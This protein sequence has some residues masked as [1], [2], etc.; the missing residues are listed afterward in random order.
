LARNRA[1][2]VI[3]GVANDLLENALTPIAVG[4][5]PK[6]DETAWIHRASRTLLLGDLA[7]HLRAPA[8]WLTRMFMR[9]DGGFDRFGPTR[10]L[11]TMTRDRALARAGIDAILAHDFDRVVVGHGA[12]LESGGHEAMRQGYDWLT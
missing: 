2:I 5:M 4:G 3:D 9:Y 1:R 8:P 7:F 12:V 6:L 10:I 11:R